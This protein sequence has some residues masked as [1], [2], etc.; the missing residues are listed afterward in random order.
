MGRW[1]KTIYKVK[2]MKIDL[3][4]KEYI[5]SEFLRKINKESVTE[6]NSDLFKSIINVHATHL[7]LDLTVTNSIRDL[8]K[9]IVS[10]LKQAIDEGR[11]SKDTKELLDK[12]TG[13]AENLDNNLENNRNQYNKE[14]I[15]LVKALNDLGI[16]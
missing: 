16:N 2:I 13:I 7:E 12:L 10:M 1:L 9:L 4:D 3:N 15:N 8:Y 5:L 11:A 6:D 14:S